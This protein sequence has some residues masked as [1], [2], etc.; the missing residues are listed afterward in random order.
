MFYPPHN[1]LFISQTFYIFAFTV[2]SQN[3]N[4]F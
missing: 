4:T 2:H 1:Y 3:P